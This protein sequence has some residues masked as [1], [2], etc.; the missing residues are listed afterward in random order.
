MTKHTEPW[1]YKIEALMSAPRGAPWRERLAFRLRAWANRVDGRGYWTVCYHIQTYP[2]ISPRAV[3]TSLRTGA[4]AIARAVAIE[5][6]A[7][8][9]EVLFQR[10]APAYLFEESK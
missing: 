8:A 2:E 9:E 5:C 1:S 3:G 7:E 6:Q 4:I 10:H